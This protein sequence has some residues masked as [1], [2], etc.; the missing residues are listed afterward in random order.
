[1]CCTNG[2]QNKTKSGA[3][4]ERRDFSSLTECEDAEYDQQ[5]TLQ[6]A[7]RDGEL[8]CDYAD[9][10]ISAGAAVAPV[11]NHA[12]EACKDTTSPTMRSAGD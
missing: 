7:S 12:S 2:A 1:M 10:E 4:G 5:N 6:Y 9:C 3:Q 8:N 11:L